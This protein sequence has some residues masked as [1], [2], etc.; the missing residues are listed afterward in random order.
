MEAWFVVDCD[1]GSEVRVPCRAGSRIIFL[2]WIKTWRQRCGGCKR[3]HRYCYCGEEPASVASLRMRNSMQRHTQVRRIFET[4]LRLPLTCVACPSRHLRAWYDSSSR[5]KSGS[6]P[7]SSQMANALGTVGLCNPCF[8]E[9]RIMFSMKSGN[10]V[11]LGY[12]STPLTI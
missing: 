6:K 2:T 8:V 3:R 10:E 9:V 5:N 12:L 7:A 4:S 11:S 1:T